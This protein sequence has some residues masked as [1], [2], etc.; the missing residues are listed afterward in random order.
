M[1]CSLPVASYPASR[2]SFNTAVQHIQ[3]VLELFDSCTPK[4]N[5]ADHIAQLT[6]QNELEPAA[7]PAVLSVLLL[8]MWRYAVCSVNLTQPLSSC[9]TLIKELQQWCGIDLVFG[10]HHPD[11]GFLAL[12]PKNPAN[13]VFFETF[14][15]NELLI[16]YAGR[17]NKTP[18]EP[19]LALSVLRAVKD[20]LAGTVPFVPEQVFKGSFSFVKERKPLSAG[21]KTSG[22]RKKSGNTHTMLQTAAEGGSQVSAAPLATSGSMQMSRQI[23]VAVTNELFH[24]GNVEAWKRI[25]RSYT[26][27]YPKNRVIIFYDGEQITNINTLFKWGKVKHGS[28]IQFAVMGEEVKD[29]SKLSRY[30]AEGASPRFEV[31]LQGSPSGILNLF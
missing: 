22:A 21:K 15:K 24:N 4:K 3:T 5:I 13:I 29:L 6:A 26:A 20:L 14:K 7:V 16:I 23:S 10:Y 8:D 9:D 12:N 19:E 18:L 30:F 27:R 31:F 1:V 2:N 28:S 11:L 17:Q 25:I